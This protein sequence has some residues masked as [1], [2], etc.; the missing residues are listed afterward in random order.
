MA[1]TSLT[2]RCAGDLPASARF[3]KRVFSPSFKRK[4]PSPVIPHIDDRPA[5]RVG[6]IECVIEMTDVRMAIVFPFADRIGVADQQGQ[7][8]ACTAGLEPAPAGRRSIR[9]WRCRSA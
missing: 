2:D 3:A 6:L 9:S 5:L 8:R 7:P 1:S 4:D